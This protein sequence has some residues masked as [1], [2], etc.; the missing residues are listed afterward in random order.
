VSQG[1]EPGTLASSA[2]S[3]QRLN[4]VFQLPQAFSNIL[5]GK[6][7]SES[8]LRY[9]VQRADEDA[10]PSG[11]RAAV[12]ASVIE[13]PDLSFR[14]AV[15]AASVD[16]EI[17]DV[18]AGIPD[19]EAP[20]S[21]TKCPLSETKVRGTSVEGCHRRQP[22]EVRL[23]GTQRWVLFNS[24]SEAAEHHATAGHNTLYLR[25]VLG[26]ILN[27]CPKAPK[28]ALERFEIRK[29]DSPSEQGANRDDDDDDDD[30]DDNDD[31]NDDD[32]DDE[33]S[34]AKGPRSETK[35]RG[36]AVEVTP[37]RQPTRKVDRCGWWARSGG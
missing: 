16:V 37:R 34:M 10:P 26:K 25:T 22:C 33:P 2:P 4:Q 32:D 29:V 21:S 19:V 9:E 23:V 15:R 24:L 11:K 17:P 28:W 27:G 3:I 12:R 18:E 8:L 14:T 5:Q 7:V 35:V 1:C 36:T 30:D 20:A 31:D 13:I 6:K